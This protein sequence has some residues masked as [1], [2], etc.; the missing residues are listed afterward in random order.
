MNSVVPM[1]PEP[2]R[3]CTKYRSSTRRKRLALLNRHPFCHYCNQ[4]LF[5]RTST[6]DHKTPVSQGGKS[7]WS[8]VVLACEGCNAEKADMTAD[9]YEAFKWERFAQTAVEENSVGLLTRT[10]TVDTVFRS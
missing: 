9:E 1:R 10:E 6:V 2:I 8:N 3:S 4:R 7:T 5:D